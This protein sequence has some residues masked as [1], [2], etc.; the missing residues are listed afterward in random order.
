MKIFACLAT[1]F[2]G[3]ESAVALTLQL[4]DD[5][6]AN[7]R[8]DQIAKNKTTVASG[9]LLGVLPSVIVLECKVEQCPALVSSRKTKIRENGAIAD[10][11]IA[12]FR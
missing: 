11:N 10:T 7:E 12:N 4:R 5:A 6:L 3:S 1:D 2:V 9:R 8:C